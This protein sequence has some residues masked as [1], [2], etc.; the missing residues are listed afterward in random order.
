MKAITK[1]VFVALLIGISLS[2][3]SRVRASS[4]QYSCGPQFGQCQASLQQWMNTCAQDCSQ[5]AGYTG[6]AQ[7]CYTI[8]TYVGDGVY[9]PYTS[10]VLSSKSICWDT[11]LN[12]ATCISG[13]VNQFNSQYSSCV[14][15]YCTAE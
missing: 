14:S 8:T 4:G 15:N 13:C 7:Y 2:L 1:L 6:T 11:P 5:Y 3:P 12:A 9:N 10:I